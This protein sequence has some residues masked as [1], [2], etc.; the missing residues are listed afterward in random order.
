MR[1]NYR[2]NAIGGCF[3][4]L[5]DKSLVHPSIKSDVPTQ[6]LMFLREMCCGGAGRLSDI[7]EEMLQQALVEAGEEGEPAKA[8]KSLTG[9][10]AE[11]LSLHIR[12][13]QDPAGQLA[14]LIQGPLRQ[15]TAEAK[16]KK[17]LE[18]VHDWPCKAFCLLILVSRASP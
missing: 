15:A 7:A 9:P 13:H 4:S 10:L 14:Q 8:W 1:Q 5:R 11:L 3:P 18:H 6:L 16:G 2:A 12:H 17:A